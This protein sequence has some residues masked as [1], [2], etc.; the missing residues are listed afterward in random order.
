MSSIKARIEKLERRT[1]PSGKWGFVVVHDESDEEIRA[2]ARRQGFDV[3]P[4]SSDQ[5]MIVQMVSAKS[6]PDTDH[7]QK[8]AIPIVVERSVQ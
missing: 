4:G 1:L 8:R 5:I 7:H 3:S 2:I 6:E